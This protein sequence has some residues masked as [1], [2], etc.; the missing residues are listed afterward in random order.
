MSAA[1]EN[2]KFADRET[3][4]VLGD[5]EAYREIAGAYGI[6]VGFALES[7][8]PDYGILVASDN[9]YCWQIPE[10]QLLKTDHVLT[11]PS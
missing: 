10:S 1:P 4:Q 11:Y 6:V 9:W 5:I 7:D 3:V 2:L 8:P